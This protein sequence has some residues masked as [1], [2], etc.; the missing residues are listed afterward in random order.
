MNLVILI[1][2]VKR[3]SQIIKRSESGRIQQRKNRPRGSSYKAKK[4]GPSTEFSSAKRN[5]ERE[6]EVDD[7]M[8]DLQEPF[9]EGS[10][11]TMHLPQLQPQGVTPTML[12]KEHLLKTNLRRLSPMRGE[13]L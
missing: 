13:R 6:E 9:T 10:K 2:G 12:S 11:K 3:N 7:T 5:F 8:L 4:T 1:R